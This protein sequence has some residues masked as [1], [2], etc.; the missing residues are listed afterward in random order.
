MVTCKGSRESRADSGATWFHTLP[1]NEPCDGLLPGFTGIPENRVRPFVNLLPR[2]EGKNQK[3][4]L[5]LL[6][7]APTKVLVK[8]EKGTELHERKKKVW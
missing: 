5:L 2:T 7:Q 1:R 3:L 8:V 6:M 4:P